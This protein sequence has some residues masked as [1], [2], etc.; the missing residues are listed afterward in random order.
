LKKIKTISSQIKTILKKIKTI[1]SQIKTI[2]KKIK[3]KFF[4]IVFIFSENSLFQA[5]H[6][7]NQTN[8]TRRIEN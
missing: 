1:S 8:K 4:E 2:L 6:L 3:T 5:E 7:H